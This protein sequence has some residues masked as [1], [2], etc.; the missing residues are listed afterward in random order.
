MTTRQLQVIPAVDVL[1]GRAV[2]L[3]QGDYD[4][5]TVYGNDPVAVARGFVAD[6]ASLVH[7]VDLDGARTGNPETAPWAAFGAA[8]IPFQAAGGIRTAAAASAALGA[9][10]Q[11]VILGTAAVWNPGELRETTAALGGERVVAA[12]DVRDGRAHGSGW[13]D[14]GRPV[15]AVVDQLV[16]AGAGRLMVT[17]IL[18]DGTMSGPDLGLLRSIVAQ[19]D[20][21]VIAAGG[22]GSL[23]DLCR[24]AE[25][26]AEAVVVGRALYERRFSLAQ[27]IDQ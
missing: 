4:T 9:G 22:I 12:L 16:A 24:V 10:A 11:R 5:V 8:D 26:G 21:P 20:V 1:G 13:E 23:D 15:A 19:I 17:A 14:R 7:V 6:G 25:T 2:R 18:R 27:A 3:R